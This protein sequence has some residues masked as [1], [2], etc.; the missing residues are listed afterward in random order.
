MAVKNMTKVLT[1]KVGIEELED[2]MWRKIEI[3]DRRT[4]AD[5]A[6]TI[7]ATFA[8]FASHLYNIKYR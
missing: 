6:Y 2:K 8:S 7:L 4:I 5:L 1:F 3:I